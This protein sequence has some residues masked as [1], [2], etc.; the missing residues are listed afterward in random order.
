MKKAY[1]AY[2]AIFI[3]FLT[4]SCSD[5]ILQTYKNKYHAI[6]TKA[7]NN[8]DYEQENYVFL[9]S[10]TA[11]WYGEAFQGRKTANGEIYDINKLT[12]AHPNLPLPST[13]RVTNL[14]NNKTV[15]VK[16]NDRGPYHGKRV[17]DLSEKASIELGFKD[18]GTAQIKIELL[19]EEKNDELPK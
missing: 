10:G 9:E 3:L 18:K 8:S 19:K 17:L 13:I 12:A 14:D 4:P 16:V 5:K 7:F 15:I 6:I 1:K 2:L 11:S